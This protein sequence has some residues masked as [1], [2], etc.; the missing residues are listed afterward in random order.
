MKRIS[1][2]IFFVLGASL[3]FPSS[4]GRA[5]ELTNP[6]KLEQKNLVRIRV[7]VKHLTG[8]AETLHED[9]LE[10]LDSGKQLILYRQAEAVLVQLV[11]LDES[12]S[13]ELGRKRLYEEYDQVELKLNELLKGV[14]ALGQGEKALQRQALRV[15]FAGDDVYYIISSGDI[16]PERTRNVIERQTRT[17]DEAAKD[18]NRSAK[19]ALGGVPGRAV[20]LEAIGMLAEAS[21]KCRKN[22]ASGIKIDGFRDDFAALTNAWRKVID[23]MEALSPQED[24]YLLRSAGRIDLLYGRLHERLEIK[25]K[26][27]RL[28]VRS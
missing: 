24:Y 2:K 5:Q 28:S 10:Y 8:Q 12:L 4:V 13:P 18:L 3:L 15:E 11:K 19:Y 21:G 16:T 14:R 7:A 27:P 26:C 6:A 23:Q 22:L 17:L 1:S 25:G 20:G 9:V